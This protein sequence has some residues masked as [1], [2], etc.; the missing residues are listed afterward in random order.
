[1]CCFYL[2]TEQSALFEDR[3]AENKEDWCL[4]VAQHLFSQLSYSGEYTIDSGYEGSN[5]KSCPCSNKDELVGK[6]GDTSFGKLSLLLQT[7]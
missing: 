4:R 6:F 5:R 7:I 2:C 1:L 3:T